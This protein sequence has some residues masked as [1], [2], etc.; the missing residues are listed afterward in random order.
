[1]HP[2][3]IACRDQSNLAGLEKIQNVKP[4]AA[5]IAGAVQDGSMLLITQSH[6]LQC[7]LYFRSDAIQAMIPTSMRV[8]E[9]SQPG[10]PE[11]L[12]IANRPTPSPEAGEVLIKVAAAGVNRPDVAQRRGVYPPPPGVT[13]IPGL[14][15]AGTVVAL[16]AGVS[17]WKLGEE[18]C[19]LVAGGGYAE[20][21]V[22]P[23]PQCLP[24]PKGLT[25]IEAA[26][27]PE[28]FFTVW[29]N[30]FERARLSA[31]DVFLVQGGSSGIGVTAIQLVK[32]FGNRVFATAGTDEKCA[33]CVKLGADHAINYKTEDFVEVINRETK[34]RGVDVVLDMVAGD[35]LE[36]EVKCLADEGRISVIASLGGAKSTLFMPDITRKRATITGSTL[37]PRSVAFKGTIAAALREKVWPKIESGAIKPV[38]YKTFPLDQA[39]MAHAL[40]ESSQHIGK[41]VLTV[42]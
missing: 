40:M 24:I 41:I 36:R 42:S 35:Y 22:A 7:A 39:A 10:P 13:D 32:A 6:T 18:L 37:R 20:Y 29:L 34:G 4:T 8:A 38:I 23:A 1:V 28:T 3:P 15:I 2:I 17:Q 27:L 11:G 33:A 12:K 30:V 26:S 9:I 5:S 21:C 25:L 31:E 16:G 14:E 19:A